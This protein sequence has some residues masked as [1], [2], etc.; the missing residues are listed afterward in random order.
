M[1]SRPISVRAWVI[2]S[3]AVTACSSHESGTE[4]DEACIAVGASCDPSSSI[5]CRGSC[6]LGLYGASCVCTDLKC[7]AGTT[8]DGSCLK[9]GESAHPTE[10]NPGGGCCSGALFRSDSGYTCCTGGGTPCAKAVGCCGGKCNSGSCCLEPG[11]SCGSNAEC[12]AGSCTPSGACCVPEG[13]E[14]T[15]DTDCCTGSCFITGD[16]RHCYPGD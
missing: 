14:C 6:S 16:R 4:K 15:D 10:G 3:L 5:C 7:L 8:S 12:C 1:S 13:S 11:Q 9:S 2:M